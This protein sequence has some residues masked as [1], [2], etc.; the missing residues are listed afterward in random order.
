[1]AFDAKAKFV[2][3]VTATAESTGDGG[4]LRIADNVVLRKEGA[5]VCRPSFSSSALSRAYLASFP[6]KGSP[7]YIAANNA[8]Y[9]SSQALMLA[10]GVTTPALRADIQS[11]KEARGNF[12][13]AAR[14]GVYKVPSV[15]S[16]LERS[17][18]P[19]GDASLFTTAAVV[20]GTP[21]FLANNQHVAYRLVAKRTDANGVVIRARPTGAF[22][23]ANAS[24]SAVAPSVTINL[25]VGSLV[26]E[27]EVYRT[28]AF[29]T[30]AQ[31]DDE[32]QLVATIA[33]SQFVGG[34][35]RLYTFVDR[36]L[37]TAR[38]T[39][40]YTSPS[41]G[42]AEAANDRPPG[43]ACLE[44]F[45]G[46]LFFGNTMGPQRITFSY[47]YPTN[48]DRTGQA[49]GIG[50]R[51][52]TGST[53]NGSGTITGVSPTTGLQIGMTINGSGVSAVV[54]SIAGTT[55]T[56]SNVATVTSGSNALTFHDTIRYVV[57]ASVY[58]AIPAY[59]S[60]SA[61]SYAMSFNGTTTAY[62]I[63]PAI[64]GYSSTVVFEHIDRGDQLTKIS[65]T[66]GD[67]YSPALPLVSATALTLSY[68]SLPNGLAWSEPDEPEHCPPKNFARVGDT[69]KAILGLVATRDRLL[70]FKEDGLFMLTGDTAANFAIYPLDTTCLCILPGSIRRLQNTVYVLTNLGLVAVDESGGVTVVSRP[71][72]NEVATIVNAIRA[73][74]KASGLY[75]MPG[76]SG[77][78]GAG[79]DAN[80]EYWLALGSST[81]SFGGQ[82]LVYSL[83]RNGFTTYTFTTA[84]VALSTDGEGNPLALTASTLLTPTT[85]PGVV[86]A[87]VSPRGFCDPALLNKL[88]THVIAG[89]SQLTGTASVQARFTSST[90]MV[91]TPIVTE[92]FDLPLD[93]G[94]LIQLPNGSLLRHPTPLAV[95][96][97]YMLLVEL[98]INVTNGTFTLDM[99]GAESRENVSNKKPT[100]G[101]GA[102]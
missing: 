38:G 11:A 47:V 65:A 50:Y 29:P 37:D 87:R 10:A 77:V 34:G 56:M 66:H 22:I 12:Y 46:S 39:T 13:F 96:R 30:T 44:R 71:I 35:P 82:V 80:G 53:T 19:P 79:D 7:Y 42:G 55:I 86:A 93:G 98:L 25:R 6:Y 32:L 81:P 92:A 68:E 17:G 91:G 85:T 61:T 28:R 57:G 54:N 67:E 94:S 24:G 63:T 4:G 76:L 58:G 45:R 3:L 51:L 14:A 64:P 95:R 83:P 78:T 97:A 31:V 74:H 84:P 33:A 102:T 89:F 23:F 70:I 100:I 88:W 20:T 52:A 9:D 72:Q 18:L 49:T 62:E 69:G 59:S 21:L 2:G 99:I 16:P 27:V 26:D 40:L 36:V 48:P 90:A 101:S 41:R 43:A 1:M 60:A 5:L 15:G 8:L 73:A 75:L